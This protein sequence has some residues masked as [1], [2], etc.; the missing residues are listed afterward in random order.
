MSDFDRIENGINREV[1]Q[2]MSSFRDNPEAPPE[3]DIQQEQ[4]ADRISRIANEI[5]QVVP[6]ILPRKGQMN[7]PELTQDPV[8]A[9]SA[10]ALLIT[11]IDRLKALVGRLDND[12]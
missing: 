10:K 5:Q 7:E 6:L 4:L 12:S 3:E 8:V 11:Q 2:A 9:K 1:D